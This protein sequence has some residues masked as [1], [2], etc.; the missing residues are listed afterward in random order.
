MIKEINKITITWSVLYLGLKKDWFT[1]KEIINLSNENMNRLNCEATLIELNICEDKNNALEILKEKN[2]ENE[3]ISLRAL[4]LIFLM[5]IKYSN[6]TLEEKLKQISKLWAKANYPEEW[7]NFIYY[8]PI[9]ETNTPEQV[10][11]NFESF[12]YKEELFF[13][14]MSRI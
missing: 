13:R 7:K 8:M 10:F 9:E 6:N 1:L 5:K 3:E 11:L 2:T 14:T 4:H 12:I